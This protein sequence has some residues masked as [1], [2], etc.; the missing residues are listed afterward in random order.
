M[1]GFSDLFFIKRHPFR[2]IPH[3]Y[4]MPADEKALEKKRLESGFFTSAE[5]AAF[6][7]QP[8]SYPTLIHD[9]D[10]LAHHQIEREFS[11]AN[12]AALFYQNRFY[13]YHWIFI[14]GAFATS[15]ISVVNITYLND[16]PE[17]QSVVWFL[18]AGIGMLTAVFNVLNNRK[19]PQRQWYIHRR[20]AEAL[21][22]LYYIFTAHIPPYKGSVRE[23]ELRLA[24]QL[25]D[26]RELGSSNASTPKPPEMTSSLDPVFTPEEVAALRKF[27]RER[28]LAAQQRFYKSRE[29]EFSGNLDFTATVSALLIF[30]PTVLAGANGAISADIGGILVVI[31]PSFSALFV[32]FQQLYNWERQLTIYKDTETQLNRATN[33]FDMMTIDPTRNEAA[34][35]TEVISVCEN[36]FAAESDQWG[37]DV[38]NAT[39]MA[40]SEQET[41]QWLDNTLE[42][43][44]V[45]EATR[46]K[47]FKIIEASGRAEPVSANAQGAKPPAAPPAPPVDAPIAHGE[48]LEA[49]AEMD[50]PTG[51]PPSDDRG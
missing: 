39:N 36:I 19:K 48:S 6:K 14:V 35:M 28:R 5:V 47:I 31:L 17:L 2:N 30:I 18:T 21:R 42:K 25:D 24:N 46:E 49:N 27:Y 1:M 33:P 4:V 9:L 10:L 13:L 20:R 29:R 50:F 44:N 7:S 12:Q 11:E 37:Q 15:L 43:Y 26:I 45:T 32:A 51:E 41:M 8:A 16:N 23:R 3:D 22:S 40:S 34:I 38:L